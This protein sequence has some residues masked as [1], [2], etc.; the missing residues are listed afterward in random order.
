MRCAFSWWIV[1]NHSLDLDV[2]ANDISSALANAIVTDHLL[3]RKR[4]MTNFLALRATPLRTK[5]SYAL[6][7]AAA[8]YGGSAPAQS[9]PDGWST[10]AT[11]SVSGIFRQNGPLETAVLVRNTQSGEHGLAIIPANSGSD[12]GA[13]V[14][15]FKDVKTNPPTLSLLTPAAFRPVCHKDANCA[16]LKL[17]TQ[18]V[19]VCFGEA[20]CEVIYFDGVRF[21]EMFVTD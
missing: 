18:A 19:S 1:E 2:R 7:A 21:N 8:A 4:E 6:L 14:A 11:P 16:K 12:R 17:D 5:I 13:V 3:T 15:F 10:M 9:L 20:S